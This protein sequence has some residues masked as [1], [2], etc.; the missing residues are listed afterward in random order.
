MNS[1]Q[2]SAYRY[3]LDAGPG[4]ARWDKMIWEGGF[5]LLHWAAKRGAVDL[6]VY[7]LALKADANAVDDGGK[8]ARGKRDFRVFQWRS[9]C[10]FRAP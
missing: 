1:V 8:Y 7:F 2:I 4:G 5:S 10:V 3:A 9:V 6:C